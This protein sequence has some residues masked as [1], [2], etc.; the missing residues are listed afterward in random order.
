[1]CKIILHS[2]NEVEDDNEKFITKLGLGNEKKE[3]N[4]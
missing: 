1:M 4:T 2:Y 3:N